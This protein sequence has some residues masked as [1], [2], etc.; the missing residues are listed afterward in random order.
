MSPTHERRHEPRS[1]RWRFAIWGIAAGLLLLPLVAM[2]FDTGVDWTL[3]DFIVMGVMLAATCAIYE[4]GAWLSGNT[5][6]RAAF[7]IA[8]LASFLLAWIN[9][10]VGVIGSEHNPA[11]LMYGGVLAVAA[12]GAVAARFRPR[13]MSLALFAT[14]LAQAL[15]G[16]LALAV[17]DG[18]LRVI[19]GVT[20]LFA[21]LWL[22]SAALFRNAARNRQQS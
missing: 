13:G 7:A 11:N 18:E 16:A 2:Q 20:G 14:A 15:A 3:S 10:A 8:A 4:L 22:A 21:G 17:F 19:V 1:N 5:A 9:L 12:T 6:Y